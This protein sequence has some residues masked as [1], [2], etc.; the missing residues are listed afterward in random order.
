MTA[1]RDDGRDDRKTDDSDIQSDAERIEEL[2]ARLDEC[3]ADR[4]SL[5]ARLTA[6]EQTNGGKS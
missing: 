3:E 5:S 2:S 6:I 1:P 4:K